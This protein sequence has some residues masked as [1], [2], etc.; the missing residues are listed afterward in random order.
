M[1]VATLYNFLF[2]ASL[3]FFMAAVFVLQPLKIKTI[4][5]RKNVCL[6]ALVKNKKN[7]DNK[8]QKFVDAVFQN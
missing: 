2:T 1:L 7:T 8:L 3:P 5:R 6:I 4:K